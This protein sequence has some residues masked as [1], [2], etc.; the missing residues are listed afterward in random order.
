MAVALITGPTSGIG[1]GFAQEFARKGFDLVLVS[2]DA[3]RLVAL[4]DE[5][6]REHGVHSEVLPADLSQRTDVERVAQRLA[7]RHRP[8]TAL[9]NNA[10]FGL[11]RSF[12]ETDVDD[13]QRLLDVM[14]TATL[15]LTHAAVPGMIERRGGMI[16]N[17]SSV[18]G[19][20]TSGS[21]SAAKA[22]VTVFT[23]SL[24]LELRGTGVRATAV[25][26]GLVRTEFHQRAG[27]D[28]AQ[29]P[30]WMWLESRAV[31]RQAM[32]DLAANRPVSVTGPQYRAITAVLRHGPRS[33]V[34]FA[35]AGRHRRVRADRRD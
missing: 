31:V 33:L 16:I 34:R 32:R 18:A 21:Y 8:V 29:V 15:R 7:D 3:E 14:V 19:W 12:L 26:P 28:M 20:I 30:E 10:G 4:A 35:S 17:V 2:R 11:R 27:M 23:E 22:W 5:L 6:R 9:V 13:E 1:L 25:C 24:A